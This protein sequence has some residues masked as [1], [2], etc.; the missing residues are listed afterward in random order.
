MFLRPILAADD[1]ASGAAV[2]LEIARQ[3]Q[4]EKS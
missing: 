1:G 2:L 4:T 3:L